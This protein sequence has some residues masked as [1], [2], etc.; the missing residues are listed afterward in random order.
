MRKFDRSKT[1]IAILQL[2]EHNRRGML[3]VIYYIFKGTTVVWVYLYPYRKENAERSHP[4]LLTYSCCPPTLAGT[5]ALHSTLLHS[6]LVCACPQ[7]Q[8]WPGVHQRR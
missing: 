3:D 6:S 4:K 8:A 7:R 1:G 5:G 2:H